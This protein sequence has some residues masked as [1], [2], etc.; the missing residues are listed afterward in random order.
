[1]P[2]HCPLVLAR[3]VGLQG[4]HKGY[5]PQ[6]APCPNTWGPCPAYDGQR[7]AHSSHRAMRG[8]HTA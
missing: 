6:Q 3:W 5:P 2:P 4:V 7:T 8:S 1:M